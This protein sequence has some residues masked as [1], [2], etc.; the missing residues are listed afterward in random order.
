MKTGS[1]ALQS[2]FKRDSRISSFVHNSC[3]YQEKQDQEKKELTFTS[4]YVVI[5]DENL[6]RKY[7]RVQSLEKSVEIIDGAMENVTFLFIIRE[8]KSFLLSCYRHH[9]RQTRDGFSFNEWL[10]SP[11]RISQVELCDFKGVDQRLSLATNSNLKFGLFEDLKS[12]PSHFVSW[13]Y[14]LIGLESP[15]DYELH[16]ENDR[17]KDHYYRKKLF[18][19]RWSSSMS[20]IPSFC[21][22]NKVVLK[23]LDFISLPEMDTWNDID[24]ENSSVMMR[25]FKIANNFLTTQYSL[26]LKKHGYAL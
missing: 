11:A 10:C 20:F 14:S 8:Q 6:S 21:F 12:D 17:L 9:I 13:V 24:S 25:K 1:T 19:N 5:S 3:F 23:A 26:E 2:M 4:E 18:L 16:K 7:N 22:Y 15:K